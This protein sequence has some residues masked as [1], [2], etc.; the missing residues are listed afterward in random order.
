MNIGTKKSNLS[1]YK[2]DIFRE[3]FKYRTRYMAGLNEYRVSY[4]IGN[5]RDPTF[6]IHYYDYVPRALDD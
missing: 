4:F 5:K 6:E 2:G 1:P 3:N